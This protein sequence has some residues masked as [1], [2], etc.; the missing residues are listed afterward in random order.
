MKSRKIHPDGKD[1][2]RL[3][4][5]IAQAINAL[6]DDVLEVYSFAKKIAFWKK[7]TSFSTA[8]AVLGTAEV[9]FGAV[10]VE[11][12]SFTITDSRITSAMSIAAQ[13]AY[14]A[15][16]GKDLDEV[17][18]DALDLKA[19]AGSGQFTLFA[20][21]LDGFVADKFKISYAAGA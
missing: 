17:E 5:E 10:P 7:E 21:G 16:T 15:P 6:A 9:D 18:M 11:S 13:V 4:R 2:T 20:R 12:A 3:Q 19:A 8:P 14:A 1:A